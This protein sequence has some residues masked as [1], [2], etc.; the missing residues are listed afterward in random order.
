MLKPHIFTLKKAPVFLKTMWPDVK[1]DFTAAKVDESEG[2]L[3]RSYLELKI[4][5]PIVSG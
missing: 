5:F 3:S 1:Y 4:L 2:L